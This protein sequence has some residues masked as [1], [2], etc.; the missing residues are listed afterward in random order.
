MKRREFLLATATVSLAGVPG[1]S[2]ADTDAAQTDPIQLEDATVEFDGVSLSI[3]SASFYYDGGAAVFEGSEW[4]LSDGSRE[5]ALGGASVTVEN[6]SAETYAAVRDA[7]VESYDGRSLTPLLSGLAEAEVD[8]SAPITISAGPITSDQGTLV[9]EVTASGTVGSATPENW[10]EFATGADVELGAAQFD[11]VTLQRGSVALT[12]EEV[13]AEPFSNALSVTAA[14]GTLEAPGRSLA[15]ENLNTTFRPP[16]EGAEPQRAA[17]EGLRQSAAE[18]ALTADAAAAT[19]ADSGV[20]VD[21]TVEAVGD[22]RYEAE[23][24]SV[25]ENGESVVENFSTSGTL[26]ELMGMASQ[27]L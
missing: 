26:S 27:Y 1:L 24:D 5:V 13:V 12:A 4:T 17:F 3:G 6:V 22:A 8:P 10:A 19:L 2:S 9:E 20:T 18:G 25:T 15:F 7:M 11:T 21:N 16:E 14:G 23:V